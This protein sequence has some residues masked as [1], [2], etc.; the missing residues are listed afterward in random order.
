MMQCASDV[1]LV[2]A[3]ALQEQSHCQ[4]VQLRLTLMYASTVEHVLV[5]A[6]QVL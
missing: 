2:K 1:V 3:L 6:Q 5:F 4:K